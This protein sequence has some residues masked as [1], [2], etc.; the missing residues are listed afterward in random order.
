MKL[1]SG[2]WFNNCCLK[3][4]IFLVFLNCVHTIRKCF[5]ILIPI[6]VFRIANKFNAH[7]KMLKVNAFGILLSLDKFLTIKQSYLLHHIQTERMAPCCFLYIPF[8]LPWMLNVLGIE[9]FCLLSPFDVWLL[10][11]TAVKYI[12]LHILWSIEAQIYLGMLL[13]CIDYYYFAAKNSIWIPTPAKD[14]FLR[15]ERFS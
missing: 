6:F 7:T 9:S 15:T 11:V 3:S 10:R 4:V 14:V 1:D 12:P 5:P 2:C 13:L 8:H